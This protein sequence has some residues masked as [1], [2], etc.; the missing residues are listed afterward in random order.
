MKYRN[1]IHRFPA[2]SV[3]ALALLPLVAGSH[4]ATSIKADNADDLNLASS[5]DALPGAADI[6]QWNSTVTAANSPALGADLTWAGIE[7]VDPAGL[8]TIGGPNTLTI[9]SWGLDLSFATQDLTI[10]SGLTVF[11]KQSWKAAAGRTL[12]VAGTFTRNGATVD[13]TGFDATAT[14]GTLANVNGILGPW[15][16]TGSSTSLQYA[17]STSGLISAYADATAAGTDLA[18]VTSDT[19]NYTYGAAA[20]LAGNQSGNTLRYTGGAA[21][22]ALGTN[23]L[24]LNGLMNA[25]S[26]ALTVTCGATTDP[27]LVIGASGELDIIS[28]DKELRLHTRITG[29]GKVVYNAAGA[30]TFATSASAS[31]PGKA[32]DYSG[33]TVINGTSLFTMV[34]AGSFFGTGPVT[35]NGGTMFFSN[36][37][38]ANDFIFNGGLAT[39]NNSSVSTLN[40]TITLAVPTT[41]QL[42]QNGNM[43]INGKVTGPGGLSKTQG[44]N[45]GA[46]QLANAGNDY[47]GPTAVVGGVLLVR[48]SLYGN[49]TSKWTPANISV[50]SGATFALNV[51]GASDFSTS[52]AGTMLTNLLAVTDNGLKSGA[53]FG[54]STANATGTVTFA[55][56]LTDSSGTGG[57]AV[58]FRKIGAGT[59]ELTGANT[60]SGKTIINLGEVKVSSLN[61]VASPAASSSLGRPTTA[62]DGTIEFSA[63]TSTTGN[64]ATSLI[65]TGSGETTDRVINLINQLLGGILDQSGTGLLKFTSDLKCGSGDPAR[66][67]RKILMLRGSTDGIGEI[68]GVIPNSAANNVNQRATSI[69]KSGSG[70]WILSGANTYT[71]TTTVSDGTLLVNNTTGSGTG[72]G[73]VSVT[74]GILGGG[75]AITG[76]VTIGNSAGSADAI[77]APGNSIGAIATGN[78]AF[79]SDGS[80]AC[81]LSGSSA[82]S[83]R[84]N[85]TGTVTINATATLTVSLTGSLAGGQRYFI[86]VNDGADA[87]TGTFASLP[88]DAVVGT[89]GG[90]DLKISYTGDSG[91]SAITGGNDIVLYI[92]GAAL[93]PYQNWASG[94]FAKPFTDTLPGVDFDNDGLSNLQEFVLGGD[95]TISQA[96]IAPTASVSGGNLELTF[97]RSDASKL[98]PA[99]TVKVEL[100]RDLTFS[101][102]ADAITI[103]PASDPGPIAPSGASYTV[104]NSGG[105]DT[106]TVRIPQGA[107]PKKFVRVKAIQTP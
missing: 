56:P 74:T 96:G 12:N 47:A 71:G 104:I 17:T 9:G 52:D 65:Y 55:T 78:L 75:G 36:N 6:V 81:E 100:S 54:L 88:Q 2:G 23:S 103:G 66:D 8:V 26:A 10:A 73:N 31:G 20:A 84:A 59:L 85:V 25:G 68:A 89:F 5:W 101:T 82:T 69:V 44:T 50:N 97:K 83:D 34:G 33:A 86:V 92:E 13:F 29:T 11:G 37:T 24:T 72:S 22:T 90:A 35:I 28:N 41:F 48:S 93:T 53:F 87:V 14:L 60:Y 57:G 21:T 40:G 91:T 49:D 106:I 102:P 76:A 77:L 105:F 98:A 80:F 7:V 46:L 27:G 58:G 4:A 79:N 94:P 15:A 95:P 1:S 107:D 18:D 38:L 64:S 67:Q 42:N 62:A 51:G 30:I 39:M 19:A 3:L 63:P 45:N 32:N 16:T 70:T 43:V 61:S 99:V